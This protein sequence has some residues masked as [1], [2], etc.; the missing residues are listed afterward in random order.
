[1]IAIRLP[2]A[3]RIAFA[4]LAV[5]FQKSESI[6][7]ARELCLVLTAIFFVTT[8]GGTQEVCLHISVAMDGRRVS[9]C[10]IL[11]QPNDGKPNPSV[12]YKHG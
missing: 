10:K 9:W 2:L 5:S 12:T 8:P 3:A 4:C 1:M 7:G 6:N 11:N